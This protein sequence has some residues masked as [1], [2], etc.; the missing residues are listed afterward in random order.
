VGDAPVEDYQDAFARIER[1]VEAGNP[2]LAELGFWR[3]VRKIKVEPG[4]ARHWAE[5]VGRIDRA[6][7]ERWVRPRF[8][9]WLG[10]AIL[11]SSSAVLVALVPLAVALARDAERPEPVLPGL[12]IVAAAGG[13]SGS[14]HDPAHWL[15]GRIAGFRFSWYFFDGPLRIQPG[16]K[17]DYASYL[18]ASP[19][20]RAWMHASGAVVSKAAPFAVFAAAYLPH[21]AAGYD[22]FP[23]WSMWIV[24]AIGVGQL[25]TDLVFSTR[26]SDWKKVRRELR[27]GR[28]Q[29]V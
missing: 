23:S 5:E 14:L 12:M 24:L 6:A 22:L 21:R 7:F 4:L 9:V 15:V 1:E 2:R 8:P 16:I 11:L 13:L 3:L 17:L 19:G 10:N 20:A 29:R 25:V 28:A 18:R 26:K 27:V